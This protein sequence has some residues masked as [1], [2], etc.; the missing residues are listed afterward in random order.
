MRDTWTRYW[1]VTLKE[2][3]W[4][5]TALGEQKL[6]LLSISFSGINYRQKVKGRHTGKQGIQ[7]SASFEARVLAAC[8]RLLVLVERVKSNS[9]YFIVHLNILFTVVILIFTAQGKVSQANTCMA[10]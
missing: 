8:T 5:T 3:T 7:E 9:G 2:H 10:P 1:G 4:P 6:Y